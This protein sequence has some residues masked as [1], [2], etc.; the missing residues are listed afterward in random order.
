MIGNAREMDKLSTQRR[1]QIR[2]SNE[3]TGL[4]IVQR[5]EGVVRRTTAKELIVLVNVHV[6]ERV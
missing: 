1:C 3:F 4:E 2:A 6:L 5:D